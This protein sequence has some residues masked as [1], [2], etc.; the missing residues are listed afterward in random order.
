MTV[1][2]RQTRTIVRGAQAAIL[3]G[4][5]L[6]LGACGGDEPT[7]TATA[8]P[9]PAPTAT[10][11]PATAI[12]APPA[13]PVAAEQ[14]VSP[15]SQPESPLPAPESPLVLPPMYG[16]DGLPL[17]DQAMIDRL[18]N[19]NLAP[20]PEAGKA[21]LSGLLYS[22][23]LGQVIPGTQF[24]LT[25]AITVSNKLIPPTWYTG[26]KEEMGDVNGFSDSWGRFSFDNVPPGDYYLAV[27]TVYDWLLAFESREAKEPLLIQLKAGDQLSLG[28]LY[29]EWP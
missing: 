22:Y 3:V 8:I 24:Y 26:P 13:T 28:R 25:K 27:W 5:L 4:M 9:T 19:E 17:H 29:V 12:P 2:H 11:I 10:P 15:L 21:S 23:S 20:A 7:P 1:P 18:A 6:V 14:Q 16:D